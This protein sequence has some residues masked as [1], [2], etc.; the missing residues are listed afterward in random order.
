MGSAVR[1][2][3]RTQEPQDKRDPG[4]GERSF[5]FDRRYITYYRDTMN[6][7]YSTANHDPTPVHEADSPVG[8][9]ELV[10]VPLRRMARRS[11]SRGQ[12]NP[13]AGVCPCGVRAPSELSNP[14]TCHNDIVH[15]G[16]GGV[17]EHWSVLSHVLGQ[18]CGHAGGRVM[19]PPG[20]TM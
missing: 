20:G 16:K 15:A 3:C 18:K 1:L 19:S 12:W 4:H 8:D 14:S 6:C 11:V 7:A 9:P 17:H 2:P 5:D 10:P 13:R